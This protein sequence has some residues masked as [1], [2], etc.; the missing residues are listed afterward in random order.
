MESITCVQI[1]YETVCILDG[2]KPL[3]KVW[4]QLFSLQL[5]VN[6]RVDCL[7]NLGMT[8][9]LREGKFWIQIICKPGERWVLFV[10][11]CSKPN[12]WV[13]VLWPKL[14]AMS[15]INLGVICWLRKNTTHFDKTLN[16]LICKERFFLLI[17]W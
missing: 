3:G 5:W 13:M 10:Y 15:F 7:F 17:L 2:A 8:T 12:T 11:L 9:A 1:L 6:S 4:I 16:N 14:P